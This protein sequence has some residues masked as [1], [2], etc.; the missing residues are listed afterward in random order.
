[1]L[2]RKSIRKFADQLVS[3]EM[4]E[5]LVK[6]GRLAPAGHNKQGRSF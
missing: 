2:G 4:F 6:C 5:S 3:K 1:M